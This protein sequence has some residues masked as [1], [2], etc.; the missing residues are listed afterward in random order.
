MLNYDN[1]K[2]NNSV[3]KWGK[4]AAHFTDAKSQLSNINSNQIWA[5]IFPGVQQNWFSDIISES[6]KYMHKKYW[7]QSGISDI[8]SSAWQDIE[9]AYSNTLIRGFVIGYYTFDLSKDNILKLEDSFFDA[10]EYLISKN[11]SDTNQKMNIYNKIVKS[12]EVGILKN[13]ND[14]TQ[15]WALIGKQFDIN[16]DIIILFRLTTFGFVLMSKFSS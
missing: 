4:Y 5:K 2:F 9:A 10:F 13:V 3:D 1:N 8:H 15:S 6:A 16:I 14:I 11:E 7:K 12:D